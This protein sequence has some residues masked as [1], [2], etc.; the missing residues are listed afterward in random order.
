MQ[1]SYSI[2]STLLLLVEISDWSILNV[3]VIQIKRVNPSS[4]WLAMHLTWRTIHLP[5]RPVHLPRWTTHLSWWTIHLPLWS[6]HRSH[7][8]RIHRLTILVQWHCHTPGI[9]NRHQFPLGPNRIVQRGP[10][11]K[12]EHDEQHTNP[13]YGQLL[14]KLIHLLLDLLLLLLTHLIK[15]PPPVK[16][17]GTVLIRILR[18]G[19]LL[20]LLLCTAALEPPRE[21][22][23]GSGLIVLSA[24]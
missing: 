6:L 12:Y 11:E 15:V 16:I 22:A 17:L 4:S 8:W 5:R 7:P 1:V 20:L 24:H 14:S 13:K 9:I 2:S 21:V 10:L 23:E 3:R 19:L 18:A